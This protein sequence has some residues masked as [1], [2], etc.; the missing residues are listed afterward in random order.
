MLKGTLE[1]RESFKPE[2]IELDEIDEEAA[3]RKMYISPFFDKEQR[4]IVVMRP[5]LDTTKD[6]IAKVKYLVWIVEHVC[7][8]IGV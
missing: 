1:W 5:G 4:P 2:N 8:W 3:T 6:R 7:G